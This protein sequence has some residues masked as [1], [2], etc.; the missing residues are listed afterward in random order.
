MMRL[1]CVMTVK[2]IVI[3]AEMVSIRLR[4]DVAQRLR[5]AAADSSEALSRVAQRLIDE[6]LRMAA[7]PG[8]VFREGPSGRRAALVRGPD[9]WE[10]VSLVR[11]LETRGDPAIAEAAEW[12]GVSPAAVRSALAY[13]GDFASEIEEEI[14]L[15]ERV[16]EQAR[17][18]WLRQQSLLRDSEAE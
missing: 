18:S 17:Q 9:V 1:E 8:I 2:Y 15:N 6:G 13:Y 16:A 4:E 14:A 7:H 10:V 12:L 5:A 3:M 11:S